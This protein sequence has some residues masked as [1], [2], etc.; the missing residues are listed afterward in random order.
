MLRENQEQRRLVMGGWELVQGDMRRLPIR[1]GWADLVIAG[2]AIGH[3]R[4]W[5][6]AD[7]QAQIGDILM[8]MQRAARPGGTLI[9]VE[10]LT[11]GSMEPAPPTPELADYYA[12]LEE[13]QGFTRQT[14]R[15]DYR[16]SSVEEAVSGTEFFFGPGLAASIRQNRWA[17][18]PGWTGVWSKSIPTP[19]QA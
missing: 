5:Y 6:Q 16:F 7:W 4:S 18:V 2:W 9:I 17:R 14:I 15:T 13:K 8:E 12:W 3:L 10:T 11:T 1:E 19:A